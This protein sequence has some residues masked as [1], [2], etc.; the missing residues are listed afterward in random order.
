MNPYGG[1]AGVEWGQQRRAEL[2][3]EIRAER[4]AAEPEEEG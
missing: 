1:M 3:E 2:E 4:D